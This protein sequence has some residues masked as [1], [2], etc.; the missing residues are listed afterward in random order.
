[1][2]RAASRSDAFERRFNA[3]A[4]RVLKR[5]GIP[6]SRIDAE[7]ARLR[8]VAPSFDIPTVEELEKKL[9]LR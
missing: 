4:R 7:I 2:A 9:T 6:E 8:R 3:A 5:R 1:M